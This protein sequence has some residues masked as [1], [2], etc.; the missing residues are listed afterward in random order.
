MGETTIT[1]GRKNG[2]TVLTNTVL[3]DRRLRLQT[4]GLF[5]I[6]TSFPEGWSYSVAGLCAVTG[7]GKAA[8]KSCLD[9]L[10]AAGYLRR[11]QEHQK[12]GTFGAA[13]YV[14]YDE[15]PDLPLSENQ[16]TDE[17]AEDP[18]LADYPPTDKP[19][20]GEPPTDN[21]PLL[22][23][24][25]LNKQDIP[26][27]NPPKGDGGG[28]KKKASK[29]ALADDAKPILHTY[30]AG[31]RELGQAMADMI[32]QRQQLRAINSAR[33]IRG[34]L[35]DLD[36]LSGGIRENKLALLRKAIVSSW[37]SVY[38]MRDD[39]LPVPLYRGKPPHKENAS[40]H[41][42]MYI[43]TETD[44]ETGEERDVYD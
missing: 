29:Y 24:Q 14:L 26:P 17:N 19:P 6:M 25:V 2:Y 5:A 33:A 4:K 13:V 44:P 36:R 30:C 31:D 1:S 32:A 11:T 16:P 18:P 23:K 42:R 38:P 39:E 40:P 22:N 20:T 10:Q 43:R 9:E 21:Q 27:Y 28:K 41:M 34:L 12:D 35:A 7:A 15:P 3:K 37:K 8:V